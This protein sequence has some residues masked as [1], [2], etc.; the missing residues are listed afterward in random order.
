MASGDDN[1][2]FWVWD[3]RTGQLAA[4]CKIGGPY[5]TYL[6]VMFAPDGKRVATG[7]GMNLSCWD[8]ALL[9]HAHS[10]SHRVGDISDPIF[11]FT[12]PT[13]RFFFLAPSLKLIIFLLEKGYILAICFSSDNRWIVSSTRSSY[14]NV[15]ILDARSGNWVCTLKG[16]VTDVWTVDFSPVGHYIVSGSADGLIRLWRYETLG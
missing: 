10:G 2:I 9:K 13:V 16:H 4:R 6:R 3:A 12:G 5:N 8:F 7:R 1:G 11:E 15:R 14:D